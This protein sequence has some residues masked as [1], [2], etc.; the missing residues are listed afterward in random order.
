[1]SG[2]EPPEVN[3]DAY[4]FRGGERCAQFTLRHE[5]YDSKLFV[6]NA[7]QT[8]MTT[9]NHQITTDAQ[10]QYFKHFT[11]NWQRVCVGKSAGWLLPRS[12]KL[13]P[14]Q[15][16]ISVSI[17]TKKGT[18]I[19]VEISHVKRIFNDAREMNPAITNTMLG[20]RR[21]QTRRRSSRRKI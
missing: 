4:E 3:F 5:L 18:V 7:G 19:E 14:R 2:P 10:V 9:F 12:V 21:K 6:R 13:W 17:L 16:A 11:N 15:G 20:G 1:M 8:F